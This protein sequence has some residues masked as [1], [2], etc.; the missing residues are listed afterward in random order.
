MVRIHLVDEHHHAMRAFWKAKKKGLTLLHFDSHPDM[1]VGDMSARTV[2]GLSR[3]RVNRDRLM[4]QNAIGT[5]VPTLVHEGFLRHVIWVGGPWC[6]QIRRGEYAMWTGAKDGRLKI[7]HDGN[8]GYFDGIQAPV[9]D[10]EDRKPWV[11][12]VF[13]FNRHC[14]LVE[15]DMAA[16]AAIVRENGPFALDIDEDY[17]STNNPFLESLRQNYGKLFARKVAD[18]DVDDVLATHVLK[19]QLYD[20]SSTQ[21]LASVR[22]FDIGKRDALA[23]RR[24]LRKLIKTGESVDDVEDLFAVTGVPHHISTRTQ[25]NKMLTATKSLLERLKVPAV[26]TVATSRSNRYTPDLQAAYIHDRV[27]DLLKKRY[28]RNCRLVDKRLLGGA[29]VWRYS[30]AR[31]TSPDKI[32]T[33][34]KCLLDSRGWASKGYRFVRVV[35]TP[36]IVIHFKTPEEMNALFAHRTDLLG[37]SVTATKGTRSDVYFHL[38][39]WTTPPDAFK[40]DSHRVVRYRAYVVNH[41]VG[42]CLGFGHVAADTVAQA[43]ARQNRGTQAP[44]SCPVMLQQ[45]KQTLPLC[46]NNPYP[47]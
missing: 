15:K 46:R 2:R 36:D 13:K 23:L 42:H 35:A 30:F 41:E 8:L 1:G 43:V 7:G 27:I 33:V 38:G 39:N 12:H 26:L 47:L 9:R 3:G 21:F 18:L 16:I 20:R 44:V 40:A 31:G 17:L 14:T 10:L 45:S 28:D 34:T 5:W 22:N 24:Y 37:L 11:L 19:H 32:N 6:D 25:M 29:R 4:R